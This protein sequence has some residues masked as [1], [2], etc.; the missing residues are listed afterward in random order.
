MFPCWTWLLD[1][2]KR[3]LFA[4]YAASLSIR[5]STKSRRLIQTQQYMQLMRQDNKEFALTGDQNAKQR[6]ENTQGGYRIATSVGG[7]L[8]G[9]GAEIIVADDIHNTLEAESE[10]KRREATR[11]WDESMS[12]RLNNPD[13][14]AFI[15]IMQRLHETDLAGHILE[16][17]GNDWNHLCLPARY[18]KNH[19]HPL[20]STLGFVDP[21]TEEGE[22]LN[23]KRYSDAAVT[24]LEASLGV[25]ACTPHES[26]I[27]MADLSYKPIG[28]INEGDKIIGF[29][30]P[31]KRKTRSKLIETVVA[32][33]HTYM[34]N[35]I[36]MT[37]DSGEVI[38]CTE[39]HKWFRQFREVHRPDYLPAVMGTS[40][41]RIGYP[42]D[43]IIRP[44]DERMAG[45]LAGFFDGDG[46]CSI[47]RRRAAGSTSAQI[48]FYQGAGRNSPLCQKLEE[49]LDHFGFK[50]SYSVDM[51][52]DTKVGVNY[53]YRRYYLIGCDL[54][55]F[56]KFL[57]QIQPTKWRDRMMLGAL[58]AKYI[59]CRERV[60]SIE[61]DGEE[62]VYGLTTGTGNYIVWG[63]ASANSAGQLQQRPAPRKGGMFEVENFKVV[64]RPKR[65][66]VDKILRYWDKAGTQDGGAYTAGVKMARMKA[67]FDGPKY[68]I[69][70]VCHGQWDATRRERHIRQCAEMDGTACEVWTEQE[71][72]SGGKE[73]AEGTVKSLAGF[74]VKTDRVT[75]SKEVRAEPYSIQV[76]SQNVGL[77]IED[78]DMRK[79]FIEEHRKF[80]VGKY[81]DIVDS[82]SGSF[83]MLAAPRKKVGAW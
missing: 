10:T 5:D 73:S 13:T 59:L 50:Y 55:M 77:A 49:C 12:T 35:V 2:H 38:R 22:L 48:S 60:V 56:Q 19:P 17:E 33:K 66:E 31:E 52:K 83:N 53:E 37:L 9:E 29:T 36:K 30:T 21:R 32:K 6:Y 46:S 81:K 4:S 7:A 34:A 67:D 23:P 8:T 18:E 65:S 28:D 80:P 71:G 68:I 70:D 54:P 43:T 44:G 41:A 47:N 69:L 16:K 14:G 39:G 79:T 74:V 75:G 20:R 27:L 61:P 45:W 72:G 25:Y 1:P 78:V 40:L 82:C 24:S 51:R 3:F 64:A 63:L 58:T 11:W 76:N 42:N 26:P 15:V 57:Y 62:L